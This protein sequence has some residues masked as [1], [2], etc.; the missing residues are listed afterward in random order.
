MHAM[1]AVHPSS[2]GDALRALRTAQGLTQ[3][4]LAQR[5]GVD[6]TNISRLE[7][8]DR[9]LYLSTSP[10]TSKQPEAPSN[11]LRTT[12]APAP[13]PSICSLIC[14]LT[15]QQG[16]MATR[17]G[18]AWPVWAVIAQTRTRANL[19]IDTLAQRSGIDADTITAIETAELAP[20]TDIM[21]RLI[22]ACG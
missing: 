7:R 19:D 5:L 1:D 8:E 17:E 21:F 3:T 15:H 14:P 12:Q 6:Q 11:S 10:A 22:E 18:A 2:R 20:S 9:D 16:T 4:E 13:S